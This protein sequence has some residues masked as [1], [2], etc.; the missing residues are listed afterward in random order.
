MDPSSSAAAAAASV[1]TTVS[2]HHFYLRRVMV[3]VVSNATIS[4]TSDVN[5]KEA[6]D[7]QIFWAVNACVV[8]A[9]IATVCYCCYGDNMSWLTTMHQRRRE[10]DAQ[11]QATVRAREQQRKEAKIL[12]PEQ[13]RRELLA[14]FR[15]HKVTMVRIIITLCVLLVHNERRRDETI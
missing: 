13:R 12:S 5:V 14:S 15:R 6:F 11:Y 8:V 10:A 3:E 2:R 1:A 9:L 4:S 7:P